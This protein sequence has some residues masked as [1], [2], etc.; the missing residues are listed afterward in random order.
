VASGDLMWLIMA[1]FCVFFSSAW[2]E[3]VAV[4]R[5][6][7]LCG[8]IEFERR[9]VARTVGRVAPPV[10]EAG[11]RCDGMVVP[12]PESQGALIGRVSVAR[13]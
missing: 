6:R 8:P 12:L 9:C 1:G 10:F 4:R 2:F 3:A 5:L 13:G 11:C 7:P